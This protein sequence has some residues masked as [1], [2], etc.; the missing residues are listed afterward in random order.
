MVNQMEKNIENRVITHEDMTVSHVGALPGVSRLF[1]NTV[2]R[3]FL[4]L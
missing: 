4:V 3:F 1:G 2:Q